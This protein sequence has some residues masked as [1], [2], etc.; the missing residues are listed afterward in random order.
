[1]HGLVLDSPWNCRNLP[2]LCGLGFGVWVQPN[3]LERVCAPRAKGYR[4]RSGGGLSAGG[5]EAAKIKSG[6]RQKV[7]ASKPSILNKRLPPPIVTNSKLKFGGT[8]HMTQTRY[9]KMLPAPT[10]VRIARFIRMVIGVTIL[11]KMFRGTLEVWVGIALY[12]LLWIAYL[13]FS[14]TV[15]VIKQYNLEYRRQT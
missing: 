13:A 7:Q 10:P 14:F 3:S 5:R 9:K 8:S 6:S 12:V 4:E 11:A 2:G 15:R 1:M